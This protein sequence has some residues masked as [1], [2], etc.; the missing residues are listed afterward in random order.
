M[1]YFDPKSA[2]TQQCHHIM[3]SGSLA[4]RSAFDVLR[5]NAEFADQT[6]DH[7]PLIARLAI[8]KGIVADGGNG[9]DQITGSN[10]NDSLNG[11]NGADRLNAG[12]GK[13]V[14]T[15]GRG[16]D[17]LLGGRGA[18]ELSGEQGSD[19]LD[20]GAGID[21]LTGGAGSDAFLFRGNF[22]NDTV[23]DFRSEDVITFDDVFANFAA[24]RAASQQVGADTVITAPDGSSVTLKNVMLNSLQVNDFAFI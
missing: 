20:G 18:D 14:V 1:P 21:R 9:A 23:T 15:G 3:V 4:G 16:D 12:D 24:V 5:I 2:L 17:V 6:S 7:D 10:G 13:D 19:M 22:G 11:G 8:S